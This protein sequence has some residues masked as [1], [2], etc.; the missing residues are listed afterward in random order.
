M[1]KFPHFLQMTSWPN[2]FFVVI[3]ALWSYGIHMEVETFNFTVY[4]ILKTK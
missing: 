1:S 3:T 4:V 2:T